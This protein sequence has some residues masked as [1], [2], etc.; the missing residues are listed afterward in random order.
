MANK[1]PSTHGVD[2]KNG[3]TLKAAAL[4]AATTAETGVTLGRG[5]FIV[6]V[7]ATAVEIAS[8]DELYIIDLE[9]NTVAADTTWKSIAPSMAMGATEM[10]A[11]AGDALGTEDI[12]F[13]VF[14]PYDYQVRVKTWVS[15]TIATG[16]N[17][18]VAAYPMNQGAF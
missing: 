2:L 5:W 4:V 15:G 12:V 16:A 10:V 7:L 9:A 6:R 1:A 8:N 14:N 18:S 3:Q 17:F 11:S 13:A